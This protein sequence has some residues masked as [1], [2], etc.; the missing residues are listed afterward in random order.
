MNV[1]SSTLEDAGTLVSSGT[2]TPVLIGDGSNQIV[3]NQADFVSDGVLVGDLVINDTNA[4]FGY[5]T[6]IE[7]V[8]R[9]QVERMIRPRDGE[10]SVDNKVGDSYRV[11]RDSSTGVS[12][13]V[14]S[15]LDENFSRQSEFVLMNGTNDV[16]TALLYMRIENMRAFS[17]AAESVVGF[18][19]ATTQIEELVLCRIENDNNQSLMSLYTVPSGFTGYLSGW[20]ASLADNTPVLATF[21]LRVGNFSGISY[22]TQQKSISKDSGGF[23]VRFSPPVRLPQKIDVWVNGSS[24]SNNSTLASGFTLILISNE[25]N[26]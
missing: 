9:L 4:T 14:I 5:V 22:T 15:G 11:V 12:V 19:E 13:V 21:R 20:S 1:K 25:L 2:T 23:D 17:T 7:S 24:D 3:D 16:L 26:D 10:T 6:S 18:I 8:I